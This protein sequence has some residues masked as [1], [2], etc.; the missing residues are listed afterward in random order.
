MKTVCEINKCCGC[1]ACINICPK[2]CITVKDDIKHFNAV[3]DDE[4][5]IH[6][7]LCKKVC[8][9]ENKLNPLIRLRPTI[10]CLEGMTK[11]S[12]SY[13]NSSSGGFA[14][15]L[16]I[17]FAKHG[18]YVVGVSN[19]NDDFEF[20]ITNNPNDI[21]KFSGSKYVKISTRNIYKVIRS[22]LNNNEK[23]LFFGTPCQVAGLKLFLLKE[24]DN[25]YTIDLICHGTPSMKVLDKYLSEKKIYTHKG[26]TFRQK[27]TMQ[28]SLNENPLIEKKVTDP[29]LIG[30]KNSLY[31]TENC[32]ECRY[33]TGSRVSDITIGDSWGSNN[34]KALNGHC[35][36]LILAQ[37][38]KGKQLIELVKD[39]FDLFDCDYDN[40]IKHNHQLIGPS[41][42]QKYTDYYFDNMD[43]GTKTI[44]KKAYPKSYY[45]Q[46]I[47][48]ILVKMHLY[49]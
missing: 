46:L 12:L 24:Y 18:G 5:C 9:V 37:T 16:G 10:Q 47:K 29:Y 23:V 39:S 36:S 22:K 14:T 3:I 1:N 20:E 41:V 4:K 28:L 2:Q 26:L 21:Y 38:N 30:F 42:K 48:L 19:T 17:E 13:N 33:A 31:L 45:K 6:C 40:A 7:N 49:R 32:Y 8:Q 35:F 43:K 34:E 11:D 44:I 27:H 15:C 25:L